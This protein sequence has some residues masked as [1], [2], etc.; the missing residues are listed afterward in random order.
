MLQSPGS[1]SR[2]NA[3]SS[4]ECLVGAAAGMGIGWGWGEESGP[5]LQTPAADVKGVLTELKL[6]TLSQVKA[7]KMLPHDNALCHTQ[8]ELTGESDP[9]LMAGLQRVFF[10]RKD[11]DSS[12]SGLSEHLTLC[13]APSQ[14]RRIKLNDLGKSK[15]EN[16][17]HYL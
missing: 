10:E 14:E 5:S 17:C 13:V 1:A 16:C 12:C 3:A 9:K 11:K 4:G 15:L 2:P 6:K 7:Y 8:M